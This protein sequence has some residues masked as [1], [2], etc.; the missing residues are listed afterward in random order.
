MSMLSIKCGYYKVKVKVLA[1]FYLIVKSTEYVI[2]LPSSVSIHFN[3]CIVL[4]FSL[5]V[6]ISKKHLWGG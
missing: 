2:C 4:S 5:V 1:T 6:D 3:V